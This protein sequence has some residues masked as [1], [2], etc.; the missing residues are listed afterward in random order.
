[1]L[2]GHP[3]PSGLG[4]GHP[5]LPEFDSGQ[6]LLLAQRLSW[7]HLLLP[8]PGPAYSLLV[9]DWRWSYP[10]EIDLPDTGLGR[11]GRQLDRTDTGRSP[12]HTGLGQT[13]IGLGRLHTLAGWPDRSFLGPGIGQS[14]SGTGQNQPHRPG[15]PGLDWL[16]GPGFG[17]GLPG[18]LAGNRGPCPQ[19]GAG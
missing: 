7:L 3:A 17:L 4:P 19:R 15:W 13:G 16:P 18:F 10:A 2:P 9:R 11:L 5:W 1:M 6:C 12:P 14:L 8:G